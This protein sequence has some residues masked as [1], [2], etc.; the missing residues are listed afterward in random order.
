MAFE[1]FDYDPLTGI[2]TKFD[3]D[4]D[5]GTVIFRKEQDVEAY[6]ATMMET[7]NIDSTRKGLMDGGRE[8]HL[9][10][11]IPMIVQLELMEKGIDIF[12]DDPAVQRRMFDEI[13]KNYPYCKA[14]Y[15]T[16]R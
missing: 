11:T 13:N 6:L 5:S 15:R 1:H 2:T 12:S 3:F 14:T 9:Y 7:R 4:F 16:H 8:F 10:A